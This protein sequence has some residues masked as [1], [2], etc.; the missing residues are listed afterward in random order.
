MRTRLGQS[1]KRRVTYS[2]A[3]LTDHAYALSCTRFLWEV[4]P[5]YA[6]EDN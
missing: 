4:A 6:L 2:V 1:S 3:D 5:W